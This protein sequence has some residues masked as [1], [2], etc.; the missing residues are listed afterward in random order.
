MPRPDPPAP[1]HVAAPAVR[2]QPSRFKLWHGLLLAAV[3]ILFLPVVRSVLYDWIDLPSGSMKPTLV[4]GDRILTHKAAYELRLPFTRKQLVRRAEP[5]HGDVVLFVSPE[6]GKLLLKRIVGIPGD[7]LMM[8]EG[9]LELNNQPASYQPIE[10][11][12]FPWLTEEDRTNHHF[13]SEQ[14]GERD[15]TMM[16][17]T[18]AG[19]RGQFDPVTVPAGKYFVMGDNRMNSRDSRFFGFVDRRQILGRATRVV[20]SVDRKS[21]VFRGERQFLPIR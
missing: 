15:H 19:S 12:E 14:L 3:G 7:R 11:A 9:F 13:W 18:W 10:A 2:R 6:D 20:L 4:E 16:L 1:Q 17:P 8:R 21:G 5:Q